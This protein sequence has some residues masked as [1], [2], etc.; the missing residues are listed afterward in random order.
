MYFFLRQL[1]VCDLLQSTNIAPV[2][3]Q[4]IIKDGVIIALGGCL[5]QFYIFICSEAFE[6]LLLTVISFDRYLAICN[7]LR[8]I[9]IMNHRLC[10][11]LN[12]TSWLLSLISSV[13]TVTIMASLTFCDRNTINH[14]FCDFFPLLQLSCSDTFLVQMDLIV[15]SIPLVF[16]TFLF[17][18]VSYVCIVHSVLKIVSSTGRQKA[19]STCSSH[20]AVVSMFYGTLIGIYVVPPRNQLLTLSKVL[21]LFYTVVIPLVNPVIYSLKSKDMKSALEKMLVRRPHMPINNKREY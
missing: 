18:V 9:S 4:A 20:L 7:P 15:Q 6:C 11:I 12:L 19:F 1:S 2:L 21:S 14:F 16:F 3:L 8:Y 17:I 13:I 5:I 10:F